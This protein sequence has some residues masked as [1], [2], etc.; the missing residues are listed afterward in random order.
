MMKK[1]KIQQNI[2]ILYLRNITMSYLKVKQSN[3]ILN[4]VQNSF[5]AEDIILDDK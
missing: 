2:Y 1:M 3:I 5:D 4:I